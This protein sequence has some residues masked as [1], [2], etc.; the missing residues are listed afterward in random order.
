VSI[1][2][3]YIYYLER[4]RLQFPCDEHDMQCYGSWTDLAGRAIYGDLVVVDFLSG[5]LAYISSIDAG[6]ETTNVSLD[7]HHWLFVA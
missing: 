5:C 4:T 3:R 2:I 6:S 7:P 1:S